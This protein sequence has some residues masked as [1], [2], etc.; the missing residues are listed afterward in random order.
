MRDQSS[1][2]T[3]KRASNSQVDEEEGLVM[4][5]EIDAIA[6]HAVDALIQDAM[7][8]FKGE[9]QE[10]FAWAIYNAIRCT[11]PP[12]L[13]NL[14]DLLRHRGTEIRLRDEAVKSWVMTKGS[15]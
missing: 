15:S 12:Q 8:N 14:R 3:A 13:Q 6:W 11:A 4:D 1:G 5:K 7:A 2:V 9:Q 10:A